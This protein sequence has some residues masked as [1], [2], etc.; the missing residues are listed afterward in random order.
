MLK[1]NVVVVFEIAMMAL[2]PFRLILYSEAANVTGR[3]SVRKLR[4]GGR[5]RAA[6][7][8]T[9]DAE[10]SRVIRRSFHPGVRSSD[11]EGG[12]PARVLDKIVNRSPVADPRS[13]TSL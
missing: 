9:P 3:N 11:R 10:S 4:R 1:R 6:N 13:R 2:S 8:I 5:R 12:R 7:L